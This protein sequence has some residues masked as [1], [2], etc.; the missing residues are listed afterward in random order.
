MV[1]AVICDLEDDFD[2][3]VEASHT[4]LRVELAR[5]KSQAIA[6]RAQLRAGGSRSLQRP[7]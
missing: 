6:R 5:L 7:S 2:E 3:W 4:S 1:V